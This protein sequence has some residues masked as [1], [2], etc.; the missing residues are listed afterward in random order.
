MKLEFQTMPLSPGQ[1]LLNFL[2]K[3]KRKPEVLLKKFSLQ[4]G[5]CDVFN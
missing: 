5:A 3:R 1:M 2:L 4:S